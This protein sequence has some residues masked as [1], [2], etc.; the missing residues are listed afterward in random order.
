MYDLNGR[1]VQT[2]VEGGQAAG[3]HQVVIDAKGGQL[4]MSVL[5]SGI[6]LLRL[7]DGRQE[8]LSKICLVW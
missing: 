1:L 8:A 2:L 6:Y 5:P 7:T 4:G 3:A